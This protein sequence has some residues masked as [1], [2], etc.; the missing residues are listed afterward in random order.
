M[1]APTGVGDIIVLCQVIIQI[2]HALNETSGASAE[3]KELERELQL[4]GS[5]LRALD[6][7]LET[8]RGSE[9]N[10]NSNFTS[11]SPATT[12]A[13]RTV[14][15]HVSEYRTL[16]EG[17]EKLLQPYSA[18]MVEGN[19]GGRRWSIKLIL[20]K[21]WWAFYRKGDVAM[22]RRRIADYQGSITMLL[23]LV[24]V[25]VPS[26]G[27]CVRSR[28]RLCTRAFPPP[29]QLGYT[30]ENP[31]ELVDLRGET[32]IVPWELCSTW[33]FRLLM[34]N[35]YLGQPLALALIEAQ[36]FSL[37]LGS[38]RER[39]RN[40]DWINVIQPYSRVSVAIDVLRF[41]GNEMQLLPILPCVLCRGWFE[42]EAWITPDRLIKCPGCEVW[43][44]TDPD[45]PGT[46]EILLLALEQAATGP[47]NPMRTNWFGVPMKIHLG[48]LTSLQNLGDIFSS[49]RYEYFEIS[50]KGHRPDNPGRGA[51]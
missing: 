39:I 51:G 3:I 28:W 47:L 30:I 46:K 16:L 36:F 25:V 29:K 5:G 41:D 7:R 2:V 20:R 14:C 31:V 19:M 27:V 15:K 10:S 33:E 44:K 34:Q 35:H 37:F 21:I 4:F 43:P 1:F 45:S 32:L 9:I 8:L 38:K 50:S 40:A 42:A 18:A 6:E 13:V 12:H 49:M 26:K 11:T 24:Y 22:L 23:V 48:V 17:F